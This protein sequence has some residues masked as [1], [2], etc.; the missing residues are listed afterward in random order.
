[1]RR[2]YIVG[3]LVLV[4]SIGF[5]A[6]ALSVPSAS[7]APVTVPVGQLD[8]LLTI[9]PQVCISPMEVSVQDRNFRIHQV[10]QA[11]E[12]IAGTQAPYDIQKVLDTH[13]E[14]YSL[15]DWATIIVNA[16]D[17]HKVD[18]L[19]L[20][21]ITWRES[22]FLAGTLGDHK[23]GKARSCGPTQVRIDFKGRPTCKQL[24]DTEFA[25]DWTAKF[26]ASFPSKCGGCT[27]LNHYNGGKYEV[28]VWRDV[29]LMRR[30]LL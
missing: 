2:K 11:M 27:C 20:T 12:A 26:V 10:M 15:E 6:G 7:G 8:T 24:L 16:A 21:A 28:A 30:S 3:L 5:L 22:Q 1:M 18:P 13:G 19:L 14:K 4:L 25:L 23:R 9:D 29:D 17:K